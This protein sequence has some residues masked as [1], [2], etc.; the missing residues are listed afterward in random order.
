MCAECTYVAREYILSEIGPHHPV[1]GAMISQCN[2]WRNLCTVR[3][4]VPSLPYNS[5]TEVRTSAIAFE[6]VIV[7]PGKKARDLS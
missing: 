4:K 2:R 1:F 7:A 6:N 5:D 3:I